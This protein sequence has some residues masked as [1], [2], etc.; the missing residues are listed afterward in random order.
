[1]SVGPLFIAR[2]DPL[3]VVVRRQN[4]VAAD[5]SV[6]MSVVLPVARNPEVA[7]RWPDDDYLGSRGRRGRFDDDLPDWRR[8]AKLH[9]NSFFRWQWCFFNDNSWWWRRGWRNDNDLTARMRLFL[10]DATGEQ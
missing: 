5:P 1:M 7:G 10:D 8:G 6:A 9:H 2:R 3:V 4:P